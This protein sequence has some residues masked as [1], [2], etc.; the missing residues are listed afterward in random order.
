MIQKRYVKYFY[1]LILLLTVSTIAKAQIS[2]PKYSNEFLAVGVGARGLAMSN[3]QVASVNDV[4]AGYWNPAGLLGVDSKYQGALMHAEYFAGIAKYDYAGFAARLEDSSVLGISIIRFAIDDIP[5]TRF[6][7][8]ANGVLNYD[9]VS[10]FSAADYGFLFSY[11]RKGLLIKGLDIGLNFK[12]IYRNIGAFANAWGFGLDGGIKYQKKNWQFGAVLRDGTGTFN[13]WSV[14]SDLLEDVFV[15]TG[16]EIPGNS[17]EV[18]LPR[19]LTGVARNIKVNKKIS[20]LGE[21]NFDITF[22]GKRNAI[23]KT[24]V[25]SID[26]HMGVEV[27]YDKLVYLRFGIGNIQEVQGFDDQK[28]WRV[29]PN[30]GVGVK[31]KKVQIDYAL[32]NVA[33]ISEE[34]FSNIFSVKFSLQ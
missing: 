25:F 8:D 33:N 23:I 30:L 32:T 3:S 13:A 24:N 6:L 12:I 19:I 5:D 10:F 1:G 11:A 34:L 17:L 21:A 4:T 14:N 18:T 16:N 22:D 29:Q 9:N 28:N 26:P 20:L 27:D 15:Q 31:I 7:F 2:A